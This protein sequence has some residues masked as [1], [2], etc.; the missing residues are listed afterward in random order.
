MDTGTLTMGNQWVAGVFFLKMF[1]IKEHL[2]I[3]LQGKNLG[4]TENF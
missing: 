4:I 1:T 2:N 3:K